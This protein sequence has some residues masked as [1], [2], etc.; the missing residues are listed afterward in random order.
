M[1]FLK[2][3][4]QNSPV[5]TVQYEEFRRDREMRIVMLSRFERVPIGYKSRTLVLLFSYPATWNTV[6]EPIA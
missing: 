6:W 5:E 4:L 2:A 1:G 3:I